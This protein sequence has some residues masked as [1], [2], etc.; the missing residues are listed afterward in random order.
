MLPRIALAAALLPAALAAQQSMPGY[1]PQTAARQRTAEAAAVQAPSPDVARRHARALTAE[2]HVAGTPAQRRTADYVAQQ[3]RAMGLETEVRTYRVWMPHA[4]AVQVWRVSPDPVELDLAEPVVPGDPASQQPQYPTVNGYSAAGDASGEV[5]YV[6]YGLVEDYARLDSLGVSV[7]GKVA[8]ARYGRSFR[9]I[10]ARE[11]ERHGAVALIIYSD[12]RDDGY[13]AGEV[14]PEGPMRPEGAV[15]RGSVMNGN[16][17]PATPGWASTANARHLPPEQMAIPRI[18][19][20]AMAYGDAA[21]LLRGVRGTAI[22][23]DWQGGLPFRYHVGPGPVVARVRVETDAATNGWKEIHNTFGIIR[24]TE[25][26]DEMVMV[27]AHRDAWGPGA[28]DNVSGTVSVL[29]S[30]RAVL[31]SGIRPRRTLVFATWDAE[32]W[33]L[34][35]S[36]EYVE[37]DSARLTRGGVAYLNQ[38]ASALGPIFGGGGSPSLRAALR[39]VARIVPDPSGQG[40]VYEAWRRTAGVRDGEEPSM[41]D[42]GGGSDFAGFYNHLGIPHADWG[43]GGAYGVYHSQYDSQAWMERFGDP[44]YTSHAAA[45]RVGAALLLRLANADVVPYDYEEF[46]RTMRG[47]LPMMEAAARRAGWEVPLQPLGDAIGRMQQAAA[48]F[49]TARDARLGAGAPPR[50]V[51]T[52]TND[53][54]RG[55]E[56]ALTRPEGLR[57]RPWFR[58]LI[59]AADE[60]NGYS[61]VVFP[62]VSEAIRDGDRA[63]TEREL[64]DLVA[65]FDA[66]TAALV[67]ARQAIAGR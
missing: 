8:V 37:Q 49:R 29:E 59:Y 48:D 60:N 3:M 50:A 42:P 44:N 2:P 56:R 25:F 51:L 17:D 41:G 58:A 31:A 52:A 21:E 43:F 9:G 36:T 28:A 1:A 65:R 22:P 54:L 34:I 5:V 6:N 15:Q 32:E 11:A 66:A 16:G 10:K 53:A 13:M 18:P 12:P 20:V 27:G 39:D 14:Y 46:A 26:P 40:S 23:A 19:V 35:G 24:G 67:A 30:A 63:L 4:T 64:A 61:N 47:Y 62:S 45:A 33:G 38:D 57:T 55:V 7:R